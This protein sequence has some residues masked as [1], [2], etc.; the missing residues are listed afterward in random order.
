MFLWMMPMP[1]LWAM[2]MARRASVTVSI[3]AE[4]I[5]MFRRRSAGQPRGG[6][7]VARQDD[8]VAWDE[9][10]VVVGQGLGEDAHAKSPAAKRELYAAC[11]EASPAVRL[12]YEPLI[13]AHSAC[14]AASAA[15][16]VFSIKRGDGHRADA[17]GHGGDPAGSFGRRVELH[18][19]DQTTI[20]EP[21][22]PDVDHHRAGFDPFTIDQPGL[23]YRNDE[24]VRLADVALAGRG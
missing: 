8:G 10:D 3:A 1:P 7:Y 21:V 18:V 11:R 4:T 24:D 6:I 20:I 12:K 9:V 19:A 15:S 17:T 2:V 5:G 16:S 23:A 22:D 13:S 14:G